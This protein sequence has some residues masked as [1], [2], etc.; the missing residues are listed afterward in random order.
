MCQSQSF[1]FKLVHNFIILLR[2]VFATAC[3]LSFLIYIL[4]LL[5]MIKHTYYHYNLCIPLSSLER[6]YLLQVF[7]FYSQNAFSK[8]SKQSLFNLLSNHCKMQLH[9][10]IYFQLQS[11]SLFQLSLFDEF[12]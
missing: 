4:K 1:H 8:F 5:F 2:R 11:V 3:Q 7:K 6:K 9:E 10:N 12:I